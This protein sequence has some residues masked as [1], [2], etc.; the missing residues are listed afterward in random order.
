MSNNNCVSYLELLIST[1]KSEIDSSIENGDRPKPR[2][3][4]LWMECQ[5]RKTQIENACGQGAIT[6]EEYVKIQLNQI[7]KDKLMIKYFMGVGQKPK[8]L[9]CLERVKVIEKEAKEINQ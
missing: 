7:A 1:F 4:Q 2:S 9:L 8:A 6:P 5:K 3:R